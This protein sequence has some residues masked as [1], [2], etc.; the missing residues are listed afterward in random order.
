MLKKIVMAAALTSLAGFSG[1]AMAQPYSDN[2][3]SGVYLEGNLGWGK[4]DDKSDVGHD[5]NTGF[6]WGLNAGYQFM[7]ML[8]TQ[9]GFYSSP[10]VTLNS[11]A[12][13]IKNNYQIVLAVK[14]MLPLDGGF[15]LY[16][17][18]GPAWANMKTDQ[19]MTLDTENTSAGSHHKI[20]VFVGL[21]ANYHVNEN[22]YVGLGAHMSLKNKPVPGTYSVTGNVGYMF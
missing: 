3:D 1:Y 8:A 6:A 21:G 10:K 18:V 7:P 4:T 12:G 13:T 17:L 9:V 19:S 15:S 2:L 5:K 14:G 11:S 22:M 20:T 16:G